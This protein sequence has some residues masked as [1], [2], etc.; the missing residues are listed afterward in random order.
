MWLAE[1]TAPLISMKRKMR[2]EAYFDML[3]SKCHQNHFVSLI[4][5]D[6]LVIGE[7]KERKSVRESERGTQK[8][9]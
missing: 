5:L 6:I 3:N 8:K 1:R 4:T 2:S 7:Q 9:H